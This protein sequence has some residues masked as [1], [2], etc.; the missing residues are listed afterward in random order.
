MLGAVGAVL[1]AAGCA[2]IAPL[3]ERG[4][5]DE[6]VGVTTEMYSP[7][8]TRTTTPTPTPTAAPDATALVILTCQ[9]EF[10]LSQP[11]TIG[12]NLDFATVWA[13]TPSSCTAIRND[14]PLTATEQQAL[15]TSGYGDPARITTLYTICATVDETGTYTSADQPI[16]VTQ[17]A[18]VQAA[19][20]LCPG[21]LLAA[22]LEATIASEAADAALEAEGRL[23]TGGTFLV[24]SEIQPGTYYSEWTGEGEFDNCYWERTDSAGEIIDNNFIT[25]ARRIEVTIRE[26]DYSFHSDACG[27]WRPVE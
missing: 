26:S 7:P 8:P 25:G 14:A 9:V 18:E 4:Q 22:E 10:G 17:V 19:F 3:A 11:F 21:H 27:T 12:E 13:E 20:T 6:P 15:T 2:E 1:I 24:S 16:N 23:F 5:R